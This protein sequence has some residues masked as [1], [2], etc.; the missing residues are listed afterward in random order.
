VELLVRLGGG[1]VPPLSLVATPKSR[2]KVQLIVRRVKTMRLHLEDM[3]NLSRVRVLCVP[4]LRGITCPGFLALVIRLLRTQTL[5]KWNHKMSDMFK[6][7]PMAAPRTG[8]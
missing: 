5:G 8:L 6:F 3:P 4:I 1:V 2:M 7:T